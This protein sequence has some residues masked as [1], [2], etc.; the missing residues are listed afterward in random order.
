MLQFLKKL[1]QYTKLI[2]EAVPDHISE[3]VNVRLSGATNI[4]VALALP[5]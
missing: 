2:R 3:E 1:K 5:L 4:N